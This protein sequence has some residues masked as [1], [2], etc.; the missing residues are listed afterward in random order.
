[1]RRALRIALALALASGMSASAAPSA[2]R[3][4][5]IYARCAACHSLAQDRVGPH[6][7][8]LIGRRS[9]SVA[10]FA[11]SQAMKDA[12]IVWNARSLD[13]FLAAPMKTVPGTSMTYDGVTDA[14]ER[15]DVIAY[16]ERANASPECTRA[17]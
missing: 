16:L 17:R 4:E 11:Y 8:G 5:A 9:G 10:G 2:E 7:C 15:A 13:R 3:G 6:H 1:M 14:A 12:R